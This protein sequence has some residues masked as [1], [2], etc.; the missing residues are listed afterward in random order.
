MG[1]IWSDENKF[2]CWLKVEAAASAVLAE[3]GVIPAEAAQAIAA[4]ATASTV[5]AHRAKSKP[6]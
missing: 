4:K 2:R 6:R 3:D 1:R 5:D